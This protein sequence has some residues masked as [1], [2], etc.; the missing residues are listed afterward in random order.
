MNSISND[1]RIDGK[2]NI[3]QPF[4]TIEISPISSQDLSS[5]NQIKDSKDLVYPKEGDNPHYK[6]TTT[7]NY[8]EGTQIITNLSSLEMKLRID[9]IKKVYGLLISQML[10]TILI[11]S[12]S[13]IDI[14]SKWY[15]RNQWIIYVGV[16]LMFLTFLHLC[17]IKNLARKVPNNYILMILMTTGT[18]IM[19]TFLS[20]KYNQFNVF[21]AWICTILM[22]V[23]LLIYCFCIKSSYNI[24]FAIIFL[25]ICSMLIISVFSLIIHDRYFDIVY[26]VSGSFLYGLFLVIDTKLMIGDNAIKYNTDDYILACISLYF[27]IIL[28]FLYSISA[29]STGQVVRN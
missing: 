12:L 17:C 27:D 19:L 28:I 11:S 4:F 18:S 10:V 23:S 1:K 3:K 13:F 5:I 26:S 7:D 2:G 15:L 9:F 25:I 20:T 22:V 16:G 24:L 21:L 6:T 8:I 29:I 14:Y